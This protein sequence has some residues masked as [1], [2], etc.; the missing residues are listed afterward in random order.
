MNLAINNGKPLS[1]WIN[2]ISI[3]LEK[4]P[5]EHLVSK[6]RAILLLEANFN[7]ANKI[8]FNT[9]IIPIIEKKSE[10]PREIIGRRKS[11]SAIQIAINKKLLADIANQSRLPYAIVSVDISNYFDRVAHLISALSYSHFGLP[12]HYIEAFF[13]T[14]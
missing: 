4:K 8:I 9:L 3:M 2:G 7:A 1:R 14:I 10:I 13:T 11:Q 5:N 6:L 12:E